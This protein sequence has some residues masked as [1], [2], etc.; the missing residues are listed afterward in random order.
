MSNDKHFFTFHYTA[1]LIR[2]LLMAYKLRVGAVSILCEILVYD[3]ILISRIRMVPTKHG[4]ISSPVKPNQVFFHIGT[5]QI[6]FF[7]SVGAHAEK[8]QHKSWLVGILREA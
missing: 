4:K 7:L 5:V 6:V 1:W 8:S 2:I 3:G